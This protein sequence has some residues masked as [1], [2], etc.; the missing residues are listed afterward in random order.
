MRWRRL[1]KTNEPRVQ[2]PPDQDVRDAVKAERARNVI[3]DAGA[4]DRQDHALVTRL[5]DMLAL[6]RR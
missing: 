1:M 5:V 4:G 2:A 6:R 3:V